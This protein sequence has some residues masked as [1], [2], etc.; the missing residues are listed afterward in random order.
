M[1]ALA[2]SMMAF[3][4]NKAYFFN[5]AINTV[6]SFFFGYIYAMIWKAILQDDSEANR[7]VTYVLVNQSILWVTMFLPSG[8]FLPKK[9]REGSIAFDMIRPYSLMAGSIFEVFG[10]ALYNFLFR[11]VPIF[12]LGVLFLGVQLPLPLNAVFFAICAFHAFLISF[13][14][15][16]FVGLWAIRFLSHIGAHTFYLFLINLLGG[17]YVPAEYYPGFLRY[18]M[19]YLPFAATIYLPAQVYLG[20]ESP[21][22]AMIIQGFWI[23]VLGLLAWVMTKKLIRRIEIQGG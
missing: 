11:S 18:A 14:L 19:P 15:N 13:F 10:H 20:L 2:L 22:R 23:L 6:G 17:S 5:H 16:Y 8:C 9:V 12:L 7:M 3:R 1:Y 4:R 21:G